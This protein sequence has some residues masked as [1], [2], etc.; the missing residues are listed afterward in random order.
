[1]PPTIARE[2]L[3]GASDEQLAVSLNSVAIAFIT[4]SDFDEL[5]AQLPPKQLMQVSGSQY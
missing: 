4:L 2:L 5:T 1:M 3:A